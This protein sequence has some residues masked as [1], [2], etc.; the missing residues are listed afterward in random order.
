MA[1]VNIK[2]ERA[3]RDLDLNFTKHPI[4]K[5]VNIH[6]NETA[7]IN[8]IKKTIVENIGTINY[9]TGIVT[10]N[11]FFPTAISDPFGTL[12]MKATPTKKI[13]SSERNRIITL[14]LSDPT[15]LSVTVNAIIE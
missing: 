12:V 4:R 2:S 15:A 14:D 9:R 3:F 13:F 1:T 5:D 8:S 10:L 6:T 11:D 7:I